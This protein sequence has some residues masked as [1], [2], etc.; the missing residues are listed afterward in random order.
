[1]NPFERSL[2][3]INYRVSSKSKFRIHSPFVYDLIL[4]VFEDHTVYPEYLPIE[5]RKKQLLDDT[6]SILRK[7]LGARH[8]KMEKPEKVS[9]IVK[10]QSVDKK[11]GRLLF[12]IT[13][14]FKPVNIIELGTSFG[15]STSYLAA[16][17]KN[18]RMITIEGCPETADIA[19]ET[20]ELLKF[21]NVEI[22]TGDF[23]LILP[24]IIKKMKTTDAVFIDGNHKKDKVIDYF[25]RLLPMVHND[26]IMIFD[27]I[28]WSRDMEDAWKEI[29]KNEKVR[30]SIDLFR[31]GLLFFK[32]ELSK[33]SFIIRYS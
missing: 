26:T 23:D 6:R 14:R 2:A 21:N 15:I 19:K 9:S 18:S 13:R 12:R 22:Q 30:I 33:E 28:H 5:N 32:K 11:T 8:I 27:D 29:C 25:I 7:D 31:F 4:N 17:N 20:F 16:A 10:G 24:L 1:M 3:W